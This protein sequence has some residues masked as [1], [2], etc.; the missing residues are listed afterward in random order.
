M[1]ENKNQNQEVELDNSQDLSNLTDDELINLDSDNFNP[2][3]VVRRRF[4]NLMDDTKTFTNKDIHKSINEVEAIRSKL[5]D[6]EDTLTEQVKRHATLSKAVSELD[7]KLKETNANSD[8][9]INSPSLHSAL[10]NQLEKAKQ[11]AVNELN[12]IGDIN[13]INNRLNKI[14]EYSDDLDSAIDDFKTNAELMDE[15]SDDVTSSTKG[16][17]KPSYTLQEDDWSKTDSSNI[18]ANQQSL[19]NAVDTHTK[20]KP[21]SVKELTDMVAKTL[22]VDI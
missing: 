1:Q 11:D 2:S 3:E 7:T 19:V 21:K 18:T 10:V 4:A 17:N 13:T 15:Y 6:E 20:D 5:I 16:N 14:M 9:R 8:M 12:G 22:G